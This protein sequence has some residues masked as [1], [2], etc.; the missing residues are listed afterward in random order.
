MNNK[1]IPIVMALVVGIILAG[2]VLMPVLND[3]TKTS[4]TF[5]NSGSGLYAYIS[6]NDT[7]TLTWSYDNPTKVIVNGQE[8]NAVAGNEALAMG[9]FCVRMQPTSSGY[10]Q[11]IAP[12]GNVTSNASDS[13]TFSMSYENGTLTII[14]KSGTE[15][16]TTDGF[17]ALSPSGNYTMKAT[18]TAAYMNA[19]TPLLVMGITSVGSQWNTG[20]M[21]T[22]TV[23]DYTVEQWNGTTEFVIS[24]ETSD[25]TKV[26]GYKDL[27]TLK[28]FQWKVDNSGTPQTVTYN[29][30][31]VPTTVSGELDN[32]LNPAEIAIMNAIP[33]MVIIALLI[34]AVGVVARRND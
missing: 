10:V 27:Y 4:D 23:T 16:L 3:A 31:L 8:L 13:A 9:D 26:D 32:H 7:Y 22:G 29:Y 6:E 11:Y 5:Q 17:Y 18:T 34:V 12:S 2:S 19:D 25:I 21:V 1:L 33:V 15:T 28:Q 30:F 14:G 24:D 20:F